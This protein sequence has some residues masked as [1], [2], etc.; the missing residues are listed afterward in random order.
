MTRIDRLLTTLVCGLCLLAGSAFSQVPLDP[1]SRYVPGEV[2]LRFHDAAKS[3]DRERILAELGAVPGEKSGPGPVRRYRLQKL[4]VAEAVARFAHDPGLAYLEPNFLLSIAAVPDDPRF[5]DLWGLRNQGLNGGTAG[6]DIGAT[7]AW[8]VT[9]EAHEILVGVVDTGVDYLHEDLRANIWVNPGEIAGNGID[10]DGNGFIDDVHGYDFQ[11]GDGDPYDENGHGTHVSGTIGAVGSNGIGVTGVCWR[12]NIVALRTL[13]SRGEGTTEDAIRAIE[14]AIDMGVDILNNS[15]GGS[16]YSTAM[17]EAISAAQEAGILFVAAAG[18][19]GLSNEVVPF[20]PASYPQENI[21]SVGASDRNDQ[22]VRT[23]LWGSNYGEISVDLL[24]PGADILSCQPGNLYGSLSGTSMATPHV[25]GALAL[26]LAHDSQL[27]A[28]EAKRILLEGVAVLPE[29]QSTCV[30]SGRLSLPSIIVEPDTIPPAE[31]DDLRIVQRGGDRVELAWTAPG[32]DGRIGRAF[33]YGIRVSEMPLTLQNWDTARRIEP[34]PDPTESGTGQSLRVADLDFETT[35]HFGIQAFD[36]SGNASPIGRAE[37]VTTLGAPRIGMEPESVSA[38]LLTGATAQRIVNVQNLGE[39][40]LYF[41]VE[42]PHWGVPGRSDGHAYA[43]T[44]SDDPGGPPFVWD[45]ILTTGTVVV[46]GQDEVLEGP[47]DIGFEFPFYDTSFSRVWIS[48]NGFLAF[49]ATGPGA[50]NLALPNAQAPSYLIAPLWTDLDLSVGG[51][52]FLESRVD[53]LI[54]Q[55][56][57]VQRSGGSDPLFFQV[58]LLLNGSMEFHYLDVDQP[59]LPA[60]VGIQGLAGGPGLGI[61]FDEPFL[62]DRMTLRIDPIPHWLDVQPRSGVVPAGEALPLQLS[63]DAVDLC[64]EVFTARVPLLSNDPVAPVRELPVEIAIEGS[65]HLTLEPGMLEFGPIFLDQTQ[66]RELVMRNRGCGDLTVSGISAETER[67]TMVPAS[68]VL[69][70]G[71]TARIAV[72]YVPGGV[73]DLS[74]SIEIRSDDP[75]QPIQRV[76]YQAAAVRAPQLQLADTALTDTLWSGQQWWHEVPVRNDGGSDLQVWVESDADWLT[77]DPDTLVVPAGAALPLTVVLDA[78]DRCTGQWNGGLTLHTNDPARPTFELPAR[79]RVEGA[80]DVRM[81]QGDVD[82]GQPYV[83]GRTERSVTVG[84]RGCRDLVV[85]RWEIVGTGFLGGGGGF[86]LAAGEEIEIG[87][88]F[89]PTGEGRSLGQLVIHSNDPVEPAATA[90]LVGTGR[91]APQI[92]TIPRFLSQEA[93]PGQVLAVP[94]TVRNDGADVLRVVASAPGSEWIRFERD[95]LAIPAAES[96]DLTVLLS[97]DCECATTLS[98][99]VLLSSNDP[100]EAERIV[101]VALTI[102]LGADL[103]IDLQRVDFGTLFAGQDST[104]ILRVRNRGCLPLQIGSVTPP[105]PSVRI[106]GDLTILAPGQMRLVSVI[107]S[108]TAESNL[109]GDLVFASDDPDEPTLGVALSGESLLPPRAIAE[110]SDLDVDLVTGARATG[111]VTLHNDGG[112]ELR[113]SLTTEAG[114]SPPPSDRVVARGQPLSPADQA[115]LRFRGIPLRREVAEAPVDRGAGSGPLPNSIDETPRFAIAGESVVE[116]VGAPD[117]RYTGDHRTR[118]NLFHCATSTTLRE[119]RMYLE[120]PSATQMWFLVYEGF[121]RNGRF[122]LISASDLSPAGPADGWFSSGQVDVPLEAD[123]YYLLV[124]SFSAVCSYFTQEE[125][126]DYPVSTSFGELILGAGYDWSPATEFPPRATQNVTGPYDSPVAYYQ[127]LVT[128]QGTAWLAI[129]QRA[130]TLAPGESVEIPVRFDALGL[131]DSEYPAQILIHTN[132][133]Q[134]RFLAVPTS[135]SVTAAADVLLSAER[136]DF[137][138]TYPETPQQRTVTLYNPGCEV[139][140]GRLSLDPGAYSIREGGFVIAPG[141]RYECDIWLDPPGLGTYKGT[142]T[143][144]SDDPDEPRRLVELTGESRVAPALVLH[145]EAL[146]D[147]VSWG[148]LLTVPVLLENP[149]GSDLRYQVVMD[150]LLPALAEDEAA[151]QTPPGRVGSILLMES[152]TGQRYFQ[153]ALDNLGLEHTFVTSF[154]Q[155]GLAMG[156]GSTWDLII[157]NNYADF[158][159]VAMIETLTAYLSGGGNLILGDWIFGDYSQRAI[160]RRMGVEFESYLYEPSDFSAGADDHGLFTFPNGIASWDWTDDQGERDGQIVRPID[161]ATAL[162][163][164]E[165]YPGAAA[166]I[167]NE[168]H[169]TLFNA[170]QPVNFNRDSDGDGKLDMVELCENEILYMIHALDWLLVVPGHG[171]IPAGGS[172]E[173]D[174][175]YHGGRISGGWLDA[176]LRVLSNDPARP[177]ARIP[178]TLGLEGVSSVNDADLPRAFALAPAVPN[179]FNPATKIAFDLPRASLVRLKIY[180]VRGLLVATLLEEKLAAGRHS[181]IWNG[182]DGRGRQVASGVYFS[183]IRAGDWR[184]TRRM[185]LLK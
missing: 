98:G 4:T 173:L 184:A 70:S 108:P 50:Q 103:V 125:I 99:E 121:E 3:A 68:L 65:P 106:S 93:Q 79:L 5:G 77:V 54:V 80:A 169:N 63:L 9:T 74:G 181:V 95:T 161:G 159:D 131:C 172:V 55:Y 23:T 102:P 182:R 86:V 122:D 130:G 56:M 118:G 8:D 83:G 7:E 129:D 117:H 156:S 24:A 45:D 66:Q 18:N 179:P 115:A 14:Y 126:V 28:T 110:A 76:T 133:P 39:G 143:I 40:P 92:A 119:H 33:R 41:Q 111:S 51:A 21:V 174:V 162:A 146:V 35:Y 75:D 170:F 128:G 44:G 36:S 19:A 142:L 176:D 87:I 171:T 145:P 94:L 166:I 153:R 116:T 177:E 180:D 168:A 2:L 11:E 12:T 138:L 157:V 160:A 113:W 67:L 25:T 27:S 61:V 6:A 175:S 105:D 58:Q 148:H 91:P 114:N 155:M 85:T 139:L 178:V 31:I 16:Q 158:P 109:T 185:T 164:Y 29:L 38:R 1:P 37:P 89:A 101:P 140:T 165:E 32:D 10:D 132:D 13:G 59:A 47:F 152:E 96:R 78:D 137:G 62:H 22:L 34:A 112:S 84:N 69:P 104:A 43:W 167:Q 136:I 15:Y 90:A 120:V 97:A 71:T 147:T 127:Q 150:P 46:G 17:S 141:S 64:G 144:E 52:V 48:S 42:E 81:P 57:G 154:Y 135:L 134:R 107:W 30:T 100:D 72:T 49:R 20:Y 123:R 26:L 151:R 60:T 124:A 183:R 149:G 88:R 73:E 82:F 163:W 53:R